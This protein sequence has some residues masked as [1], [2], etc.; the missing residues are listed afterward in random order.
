MTPEQMQ[1][2]IEEL[3]KQVLYWMGRASEEQDKRFDAIKTANGLLDRIEALQKKHAAD[4]RVV[5]AARKVLD[6][7]WHDEGSFNDEHDECY[8]ALAERDKTY[9]ELEG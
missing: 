5:D 7:Q 8:E 6:K 4:L 1:K 2:R 9:K 3:Q